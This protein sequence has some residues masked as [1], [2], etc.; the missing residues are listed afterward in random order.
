MSSFCIVASVN[1]NEHSGV[2]RFILDLTDFFV[3][4]D[5]KVTVVSKKN[6]FPLSSVRVYNS[7]CSS[8][9]KSN[10]PSFFSKL[11]PEI[12]ITSLC[13]FVST[14]I[15][16]LINCY[17]G[18]VKIIHAQDIFFSGF[19][20]MVAHKLLK[21]PLIVHAHG[22]S[23]Y[24]SDYT[25]ETTPLRSMLAQ[26]L[27]RIVV[28]NSD[29]VL[30]TDEQTRK[31]VKNF[32]GSVKVI[33]IPTPVD[34]SVYS[35]TRQNKKPLLNACDDCLVFGTIGRLEPQKNLGFLLNAF[36]SVKNNLG[37]SKL[38]IVGDGSERSSLIKESDRLDLNKIVTFMGSVT[39]NEKIKILDDLD[40]FLLP[41]VYEG[42]PIA[43]LEAMAAGKT[44]IASD[45][46]A[47]KEIIVHNHDALLV[48]PYDEAELKQAIL[49]L[50]KRPNLRIALARHA[51]E[52]ANSYDVNVVFDQL[53][54][55]YE[56]LINP[57][58]SC[59]TVKR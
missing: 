9:K 20:G 53:E 44:I 43:L 48:N 6:S 37:S 29:L 7:V 47:I 16:T 38:V 55:F 33:R 59:V 54:K 56:K 11:I 52:K 18:K 15:T 5:H 46:P 23:P 32:A 50:C 36:A 10:F 57:V 2:Q 30:V 45:I 13:S 35:K 49:L 1:L 14:T 25:S 19:A 42:C 34:V 22:P 8:T 41:S 40:I 12:F 39:E 4:S 58:K 3:N 51:K 21:I 26:F 28:C 31:L 24:F 17:V 27:A